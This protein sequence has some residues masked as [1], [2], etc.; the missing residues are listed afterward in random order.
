MNRYSPIDLTSFWNISRD[1]LP[2]E[3]QPAPWHP[4]YTEILPGLVGGEQSFWGVPFALGPAEG[5]KECF[6][7]LEDNSDRVSIPFSGKASFVVLAHFC[8]ASHDPEGKKQ[9]ADVP[10]G[11]VTRPGEHLADY[12]LL[13][14]DGSE[15]RQPILRRFEINELLTA[16]GQQAFAARPQTQTTGADHRGP[17]PRG[18]WGRLQTALSDVNNNQ[19]GGNYWIYALPNPQPDKP[20]TGIRLEAIGA[21]RV[22]VAGITLYHGR[23]HPL[24][25]RRLETIRARLAEETTLQAA[26]AEVD[27]GTI[28]RVYAV[29]AFAPETWLSAPVQGWGEQEIPHEKVNEL[30]LDV[31]ASPDATISLVGHPL[32]YRDILSQGKTQS[33]DGTIE[34]ELLTPQKVW[35]RVTVL[36]GDTGQPTPVRIHFRSA[37]GRY[38]PPYGHRHE[39]NNNWFEDYAG[40][41]QFGSTAYAYVD[42]RFQIELPVGSVYV[43]M[44]KGFEYQPVRAQLDIQPDQREL[45][46]TIRRAF[47]WRKEGWVT[48]D[49]HVHFLSPQAA[50][51]EAQGEGINLVN[52]LASQWGDLFTNVADLTGAA[53]GVSRDDTIVWVG[54]ENR[55]HLLGHISLLGGKGEPVTPMCASG[56]SESY[57]GDPTWMSLAEWSDAC[58]Q[59]E[60]LVVIPHF[61]TPYCEVAAD[62]VLGKVDAVEIAQFTPSMENFTISEWY[63][64][65]NLGYRVTAVGGTDKMY[66]GM[67]V[68]GVRTYAYVGNESFDFASWAKAVRAGRTFT[69]SGPLLTLS[70]DGHAPGDEI[71]LAA[72]GGTLAVKVQAICAQPFHELHLIVNGQVVA[73]KTSEQDTKEMSLETM[74]SISG[75]S[76]I[77]ARC[78][79]RHQVWY[80]WP[81]H[82]GAHTSPV[83]VVVADQEQFSSLE[84]R[85]MLT[86]IEGGLTWLSTLSI[87]ADP[88]RHQR[89]RQVFLKAKEILQA[90]LRA[91]GQ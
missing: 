73:R 30:F 14:A 64:F 69:T 39:V 83:Y 54:T 48:A 51:L 88:E 82:L 61:P 40:D 42:G 46:L 43:E 55:Q 68:G 53:S 50:W 9:P 7:L 63:R 87:P 17:S 1:N 62:I 79:S 85:Y 60:G 15:H 10:V 25:H 16:W 33:Q 18:A 27:L 72:G 37:D 26:N 5:G 2:R 44:A 86:L 38:F 36:D 8:N 67:P 65:L 91:H 66:S 52:L 57:I 28:S 32:A 58:R 75:S 22:A 77:A 76:W 74:V 71:R 56:P 12:V 84:A 89:V 19:A 13:Y 24:R 6:I 80:I 20:L 34:A 41:T 23:Y 45:T 29:P 81:K 31:T 90:R 70:V 78:I 35:V 21:D 49:T 59:R 11:L 4:R 47:N 3:G